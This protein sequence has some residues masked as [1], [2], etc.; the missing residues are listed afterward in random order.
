VALVIVITAV[1]LKGVLT[2]E[3]C[4]GMSAGTER[5]SGDAEMTAEL[6]HW[7]LFLRVFHME[8]AAA[9][10]A[11]GAWMDGWTDEWID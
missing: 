7:R 1:T 9:G 6:M 5:F 4:P 3:Q 8:E 11:N 2:S 10:K